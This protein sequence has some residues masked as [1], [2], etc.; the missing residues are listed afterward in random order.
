[1]SKVCDSI[2]APLAQPSTARG[3]ET[4]TFLISTMSLM[5]RVNSCLSPMVA[6]LKVMVGTPHSDLGSRTR[7]PFFPSSL[8]G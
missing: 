1:M 6:E 7:C 5:S 4:P 2:S 8:H 3:T